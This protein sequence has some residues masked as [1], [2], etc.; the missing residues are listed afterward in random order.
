M[1]DR[2]SINTLCFLGSSFRELAGYWHELGATRVS[3]VSNL[4]LQ[5]GVSAAREALASGEFRVET[6]AHPFVNAGHLQAGK[7]W[8]VESRDQLL[9]VIDAGSIRRLAVIS[10][11]PAGPRSAQPAALRLLVLP[12]LDRFFGAAYAVQPAYGIGFKPDVYLWIPVVGNIAAVLVI[13]F[14]GNL[15]DKIGRRPPIIVGALGS[16]HFAAALDIE[17]KW[18]AIAPP[19]PIEAACFY[20]QVR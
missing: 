5:E 2:V 4:L 8:W 6:I 14:V 9:Q 18:I 3:M 12:I 11:S 17:V 15:S 13:P 1:H 20:R 19:E 16:V 7:S 10:A